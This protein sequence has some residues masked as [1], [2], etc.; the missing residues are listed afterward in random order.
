M[1]RCNLSKNTLK[2]FLTE[3]VEWFLE[4]L[5][6]SGKRHSFEKNAFKVWNMNFIEFYKS[7][8]TIQNNI[9]AV[10]LCIFRYFLLRNTQH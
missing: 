9:L 4:N 5:Y 7:K 8:F 1:T 6:R 2:K 3:A 10:I